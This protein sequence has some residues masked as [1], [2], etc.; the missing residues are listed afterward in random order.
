MSAFYHCADPP[1]LPSLIFASAGRSEDPS[2]LQSP[3]TAT[4]L[5]FEILQDSFISIACTLA[6]LPLL[7]ALPLPQRDHKSLQV[8]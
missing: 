8:L 1:P 6:L 3:V 2:S 5:T 4:F 7:H